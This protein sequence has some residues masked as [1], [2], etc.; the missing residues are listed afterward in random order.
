[1]RILRNTERFQIPFKNLTVDQGYLVN[2]VNS[3][4]FFSERCEFCQTHAVLFSTF[5]VTNEFLDV[6]LCFFS[7]FARISHNK[8]LSILVCLCFLFWD[9]NLEVLSFLCISLTIFIIWTCHAAT[10]ATLIRI[11]R[12]PEPEAGNNLI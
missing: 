11:I 2:F 7:V 9:R 12:Y 5:L 3:L 10:S 8:P 4:S 1:M 6:L